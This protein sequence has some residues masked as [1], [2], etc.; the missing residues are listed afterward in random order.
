MTK[1]IVL[2]V[3]TQNGGSINIVNSRNRNLMRK[4]RTTTHTDFLF[5]Y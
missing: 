1:L 3:N 2:I 5:F 4:I